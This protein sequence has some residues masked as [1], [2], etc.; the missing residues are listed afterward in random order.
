MGNPAY[1]P[2]GA[3][4]VLTLSSGAAGGEVYV[5]NEDGSNARRLFGHP[6]WDD[7]DP[8]WSPD[9]RLL[10][11][12]SGLNLTGNSRDTRHD[13]WLYEPSTGR[14]GSIAVHNAYDLRGPV[15]SPSGSHLIFSALTASVPSRRFDLYLVDVSARA[16]VGP[17]TTGAEPDW[18][19]VGAGLPTPGPTQTPGGV[20]ATHTPP[21]PPFPTFPP[22]TAPPPPPF[23]TLPNPEP[24]ST[25]PAPTFPP[26]EATPTVPGPTEPSP[27]STSQAPGSPTVPATSTGDGGSMQAIFLPVA[28]NRT[29]VRGPF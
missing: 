12:A 19:R 22:G 14:G 26:P 10:A 6:G 4:I 21:A 28:V 15:W 17:V 18:A 29:A 2:D 27:T 20:T 3:S 25:G 16:V 24:T 13:I 8:A 23:P 1:S 11:F 9:G 5:M 7:I